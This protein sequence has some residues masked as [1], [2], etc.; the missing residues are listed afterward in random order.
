LIV[1]RSASKYKIAFFI[2]GMDE[3]KGKPTDLIDFLLSLATPWTKVCAASRP[4]IV[5]E[6]A[7]GRRP[8]LRLED[9]THNDINHHVNSRMSA[10]PEFRALHELNSRATKEIVDSVCKK[11][12]RVF[13]WVQLVTES[14]LDGL[15]E[16]E[17]ILE[18]QQR[19]Q[20]LPED[21]YTHRPKG[22]QR[23]S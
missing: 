22:G 13:L 2:D 17:K 21:L 12:S 7:L 1:K 3:F 18:L 8:Y 14:L 11:S 20:N 9:L 16:G 5:S 23:K 15:S 6:D 4:W 10:S 19:L